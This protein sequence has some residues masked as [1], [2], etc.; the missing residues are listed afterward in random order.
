MTYTT[1]SCATASSVGVG[2]AVDSG[3]FP[4][5]E[6]A[7][8]PHLSVEII[9]LDE[10]R[11]VPHTLF[12]AE[13]LHR[14]FTP[15]VSISSRGVPKYGES[16]LAYT[17]YMSLKPD[18]TRGELLR[19]GESAKLGVSLSREE[20]EIAR[21]AVDKHR[22]DKRPITPPAPTQGKTTTKKSKKRSA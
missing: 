21:A 1:G 20:Y 15:K 5:P 6:R 8:G 17:L 2:V 3:P 22:N 16:R 18:D 11:L 13:I 4:L 10:L 12:G 9:S 7:H 14:Y 19:A